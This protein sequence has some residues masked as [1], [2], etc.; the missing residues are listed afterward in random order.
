M[1]SFREILKGTITR[2]VPGA[3]IGQGLMIALLLIGEPA[4]LQWRDFIV[5]G[6]FTATLAAGHLGALSAMRR[7]MRSDADVAGRRAMISG[8]AAGAFHFGTAA[9]LNTLTISNGYV[10]GVFAG[11]AA[12][13]SLFFPWLQSRRSDGEPSVVTGVLDDLALTESSNLDRPERQADAPERVK[14]R[15]SR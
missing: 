6:G 8:L 5:L 11:A 1:I 12:A 3:I 14:H 2:F 7:F 10:L 13:F 15:T 4:P 9:Y